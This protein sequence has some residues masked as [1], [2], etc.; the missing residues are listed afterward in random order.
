MTRSCRNIHEK[1]PGPDRWPTDELDGP[2][3]RGLIARCRDERHETGMF[4]LAALVRPDA[5]RA[6]VAELEP[7]L[8]ST[9]FT[10]S[11]DHNIYSD[12]GIRNLDA[13]HPALRRFTTVNRT[14]CIDQIPASAIARIYE[15]QPLLEF[16]AVAMGKG[17]LYPIRPR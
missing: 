12:D 1:D 3:G 8:A 10:Q 4:S 2:A 17:R 14:V 6:C 11:R 5:L 15:W 7:L 13:G 16:L 9:A